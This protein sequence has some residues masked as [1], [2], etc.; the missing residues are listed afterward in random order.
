M[1]D[2]AS[3]TQWQ[4]D[5]TRFNVGSGVTIDDANDEIEINTAGYWHLCAWL[6]AQDVDTAYFHLEIENMTGSVNLARGSV[7]QTQDANEIAESVWCG[8]VYLADTAVLEVYI[9]HDDAA[10]GVDLTGGS[11]TSGVNGFSGF[12][13]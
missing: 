3:S 7:T 9:Y 12:L 2:V 4:F 1:T 8:D 11:S 6:F 5:T 10:S 13:W